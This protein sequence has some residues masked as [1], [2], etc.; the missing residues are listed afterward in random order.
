MRLSKSLVISV[1]QEDIDNGVTSSPG[2]CPVALAVQRQFPKARVSVGCSEVTVRT[3]FRG[4][5]YRLSP[6]GRH[7]IATFD[8]RGN[9]TP[10]TFTAVS[11]R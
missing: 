1:T 4:R 9:V 2:R 7:F 3:R 10:V 5:C 11:W 6:E 8:C